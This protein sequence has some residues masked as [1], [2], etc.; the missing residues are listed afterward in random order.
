MSTDVLYGVKKKWQNLEFHLETRQQAELDENR[1]SAVGST[2]TLPALREA[3]NRGRVVSGW[4]L[5]R[6]ALW[7]QR[8]TP[9]AGERESATTCAWSEWEGT[10]R[11]SEEKAGTPESARAWWCAALLMGGI[12]ARANSLCALENTRSW[13]CRLIW[14]AYVHRA[15]RLNIYNSRAVKPACNKLHA[16]WCAR[17]RPL[18]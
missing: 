7:G 14:M 9:R 3:Q 18:E 10:E 13:W 17:F 12:R 11:A 1:P 16:F 15:A 8:S 6:G 4:W 2:W 5:W